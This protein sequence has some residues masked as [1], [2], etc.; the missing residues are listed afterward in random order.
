MSEPL[1]M[2][3]WTLGVPVVGAAAGV[4]LIE[5]FFAVQRLRWAKGQRRAARPAGVRS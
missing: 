1:P 4:C 5:A 2:L 3:F